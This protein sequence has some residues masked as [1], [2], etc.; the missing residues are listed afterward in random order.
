MGGQRGKLLEKMLQPV[1]WTACVPGAGGRGRQA[2]PGPGLGE[3]DPCKTG[4]TDACCLVFRNVSSR[5]GWGR[6]P[7]SSERR[8]QLSVGLDDLNTSAGQLWRSAR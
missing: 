2:G 5:G 1:T 7:R 8:A 6:D 3:R 4:L